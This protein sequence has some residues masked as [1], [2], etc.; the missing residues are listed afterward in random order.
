MNS[1]LA[2]P[3]IEQIVIGHRQPCFLEYPEDEGLD[4]L[5]SVIGML[6]D[7][8]PQRA[9]NPNLNDN[10]P[11]ASVHV[12]RPRLLLPCRVRRHLRVLHFR[13]LSVAL[14]TVCRRASLPAPGLRP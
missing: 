11:V 10:A 9:P 2:L 13:F 1:V 6:L 3:Q 8:P 14:A 4:R 12:L 7:Y 5:I